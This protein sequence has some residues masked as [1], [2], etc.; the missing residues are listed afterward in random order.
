MMSLDPNVVDEFEIALQKA[1]DGPDSTPYTRA[2]T[3]PEVPKPQ[4]MSSR[5]IASVTGKEHRHVN[6]DIEK[7]LDDLKKDTASFRGIYVDSMNREQVEY[8]LD[9]ELTYTLMAGYSTPLRHKIVKRWLELESGANPKIEVT[10]EAKPFLTETAYK[11]L[12]KIAVKQAQQD[13][14]GIVRKRFKGRLAASEEGVD[15]TEAELL[16]SGVEFDL[17]NAERFLNLENA[18]V[19]ARLPR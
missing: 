11:E 7:M 12:C 16:I 17:C 18:P 10:S 2:L 5:E 3:L 8:I 1:N 13:L 15:P 6:T 4:T 19:L 14:I 9:Q